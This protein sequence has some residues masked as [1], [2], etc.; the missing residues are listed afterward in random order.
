MALVTTFATTPIT[1]A[2]FPPWYQKKLA[3]WKRGEIDWDGNHVASEDNAGDGGSASLDKDQSSDIQRLLINLRLDSLPSIF[4]IVTL[5]G[6]GAKTAANLPKIHPTKG[7]KASTGESDVTKIASK[8]PLEIHGVRM[9]ELTD[10][11]SSAMKQAE[12]DDVS[13]R[14]P[15]VNAFHSFGHLNDVAVS[16]E[17]QLVPEGGYSDFLNDRAA[18][19]KSDMILLPWSETGNFSEANVTEGTPNPFGNSSYN[20]FVSKLLDTA[21]C[22]AAVFVNN[23]F[24]ALPRQGMP[25]LIRSITNHSLR[26]DFAAAVTPLMDRSHHIFLPFIGGDDDR[27]ALRFVLRLARSSNVTATIVHLRGSGQV[28]DETYEAEKTDLTTKKGSRVVTSAQSSSPDQDQ[29]SFTSMADS[30]APDLQ[31]RVL[32]ESIDSVEPVQ[33]ALRYAKQEIGQSPKNAGD[34]IVVGRGH[35]ESSSAHP[36]LLPRAE[37]EIR[38]SL[39]VVAETM[40]LNNVKASVLVVKA[41]R[42]DL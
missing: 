15:V 1:L 3:A 13:T 30:L 24:G 28:Q 7:G 2:L 23:G 20:H 31:S 37:G 14:D 11:L 18:G 27:V 9:L 22:N 33:D 40:I 16:G 32:F 29:A 38:S 35:G 17:V 19:Q 4:T 42:K 41:G 34:L 8:R 6:G 12:V 10:R 26:S 39:G 21:P 36:P 25:P 5:L